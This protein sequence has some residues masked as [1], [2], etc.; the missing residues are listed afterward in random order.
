MNTVRM[1][2]TDGG[3][4]RL[5][6]SDGTAT[7]WASYSQPT[8]LQGFV[9]VTDYYTGTGEAVLTVDDAIPLLCVGTDTEGE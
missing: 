2:I 3:W 8:Y 9:G 1:E 5:V 4:H 6:S 7:L